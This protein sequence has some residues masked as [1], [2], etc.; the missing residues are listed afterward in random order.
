MMVRVWGMWFVWRYRPIWRCYD[1]KHLN[2]S[3]SSLK[4]VLVWGIMICITSMG[5]FGV[6]MM[7]IFTTFHYH[8]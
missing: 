8:L 5:W 3:L 4:I 2:S 7:W 1:V 6:V